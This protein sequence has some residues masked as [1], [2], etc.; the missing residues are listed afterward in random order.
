MECPFCKEDIKDGAIK[1]KHCGS[2]LEEIHSET[3]IK[4]NVNNNN[5]EKIFYDSGD[6]KVTNS[7]FI[8]GSQTFSLNNISSVKVGTSEG[9]IAAKGWVIALAGVLLTIFLPNWWKLIGIFIIFIGLGSKDE[10]HTVR[11]T[12]NGGDQ[13]ALESNN[14]PYI[15]EIVNSLND[16]IVYRG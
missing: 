12:T 10:K 9:G 16:A 4:N 13:D 3:I 7:R 8:S 14:K 15:A 5:G 1:C 2:M 6:I 11:I